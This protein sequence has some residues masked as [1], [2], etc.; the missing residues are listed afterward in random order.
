MRYEKGKTYPVEAPTRALRMHYTALAKVAK[1]RFVFVDQKRLSADSEVSGW[2]WE[3]DSCVS[4]T[5]LNTATHDELVAL[6]GVGPARAQ[7]I[8]DNRPYGCVDDLLSV[9]G[10]K[11]HVWRAVID[12]NELTV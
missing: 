11:E 6:N 8:I 12:D 4:A 7:R 9:P 3:A 10:T 1:C 2:V 5:N